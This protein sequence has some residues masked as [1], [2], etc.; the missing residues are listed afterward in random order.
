MET[1]KH[2]PWDKKLR[3]P[4]GLAILAG[5]IMKMTDTPYGSLVFTIGFL[6]YFVLKLVKLFRTNRYLWTTLHTVQLILLGL[7]AIA[8]MLLYFQYPYARVAFVTLLLA[9][10]LVNLKILI[11]THIGNDN[12]RNILSFIGRLL[13]R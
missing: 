10:S 13:K 9:E 4:A 1:I 11:N 3:G 6:A 5:V 8:L 2:S 7:S 12:F